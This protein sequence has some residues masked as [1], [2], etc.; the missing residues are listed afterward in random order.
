MA[1]SKKKSDS[2]PPPAQEETSALATTQAAPL[3]RSHD[4]GD[5]MGAGYEDAGKGLVPFF[6]LFQS[7]SPQVEEKLVLGANAGNLFNSATGELFDVEVVPGQNPA[8]KGLLIQPV[9]VK[10]AF[11]E[12]VK[13]EKGGG[14]VGRYEP[15]DPHIVAEIRRNNGS[16]IFSKENP[17]RGKVNAQDNTISDTRYLYFNVL[18]PDGLEIDGQ[19][20]IACT[21]SKIKPVDRLVQAMRNAKGQPALWAARV[22]LT[23][24]QDKQKKPP[25]KVF[26][27]IQFNVF[28]GSNFNINTLLD[29]DNDVY[30]AGRA[31]YFD[32]KGGTKT[33]DFD[34]EAATTAHESEEAS[35][36]R[37][38]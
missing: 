11:V 26:K 2:V 20:V 3:A 16:E 17:M 33:A 30:R 25:N 27:N 29:Q 8:E 15:S 7:N 4:Y 10:R 34:K 23:S 14:V 28:G 31:F 6:S 19:G 18:S 1:A 22:Y 35:E 32:V 12:W 24:F 21:G 9:Y 36:N 5:D 37:N 38:F 13:R